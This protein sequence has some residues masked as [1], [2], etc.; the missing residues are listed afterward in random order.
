M[1]GCEGGAVA[2]RDRNFT[3]IGGDG[4]GGGGNGERCGDEDRIVMGIIRGE[5]FIDGMNGGV[6]GDGWPRW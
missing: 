5:G 6:E 1:F 2:L 4:Y 3:H